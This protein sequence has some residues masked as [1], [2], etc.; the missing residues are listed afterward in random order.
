MEVCTCLAA[1]TEEE[2]GARSEGDPGQ[3][4]KEEH[5]L[6]AELP[7]AAAVEE[8]AA[9]VLVARVG[10][11]VGLG[12]GEEPRRE[13]APH[14]SAQVNGHRLNHVVHT[15]HLEKTRPC[16]C[17]FEERGSRDQVRATKNR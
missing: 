11:G 8:P 4:Y 7:T 15:L 17:E 6:Q 3:H 2:E 5:K 13:H 12:R 14:A 9:E 16:G 1:V 10:V